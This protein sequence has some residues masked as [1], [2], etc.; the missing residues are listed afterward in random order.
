[1]TTDEAMKTLRR[2]ARNL[3][4]PVS[5]LVTLPSESDHA[6]T[7]DLVCKVAAREAVKRLRKRTKR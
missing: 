5:C 7:V 1:M 6:R 4:I 3:G 2:V